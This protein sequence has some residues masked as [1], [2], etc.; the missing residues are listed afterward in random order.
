MD[1]AADSES[2]TAGHVDLNH[3]H[4]P[5]RPLRTAIHCLTMSLS[6]AQVQSC[7]TGSRAALS[8]KVERQKD[9]TQINACALQCSEVTAPLQAE[10]GVCLWKKN[11]KRIG[12]AL[13]T[14]IL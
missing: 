8:E 6:G 3:S 14:A 12:S 13:G 10:Q 2:Y 9:T 5:L 7:E 11:G 4:R 1:P